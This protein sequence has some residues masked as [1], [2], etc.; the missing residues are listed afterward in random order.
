MW[1]VGYI[2]VT[3]VNVISANAGLLQLPQSSGEGYSNTNSYFLNAAVNRKVSERISLM[4]G[5]DIATS[6][7]GLQRLSTTIGTG[8]SFDKIPVTLRLQVRYSNIK[9]A[10]QELRRNVWAGQI[11]ANWRF[12]AKLF[13]KNHDQ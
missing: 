11:G 5:Q 6:Y 10:E 3:K 13:S 12:K 1:Q 2:Y 7:Y 8:Y 9:P 4:L